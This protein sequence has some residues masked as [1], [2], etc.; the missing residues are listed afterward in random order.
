MFQE[1]ND[2]MSLK[3]HKEL[4]SVL[5]RELI[6]CSR[7]YL[8]TLGIVSVLGIIDVV[9]QEIMELEKATKS[10]VDTIHDAPSTGDVESF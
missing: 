4:E 7:K 8:N 6:N 9:K 5:H 1:N 2:D 10:S 3:Q